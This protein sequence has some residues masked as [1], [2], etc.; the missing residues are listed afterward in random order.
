MKDN[1]QKKTNLTLTD[2]LLEML[3]SYCDEFLIHATD[4]EGKCSGIDEE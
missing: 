3:S 2:S 4:L 1:W